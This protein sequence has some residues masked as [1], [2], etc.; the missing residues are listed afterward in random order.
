M[1][2]VDVKMREEYEMP[3][4]ANRIFFGIFSVLVSAEDKQTVGTEQ[5]KNYTD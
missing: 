4:N 1:I 5:T 2:V 3:E